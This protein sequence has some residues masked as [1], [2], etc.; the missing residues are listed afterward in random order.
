MYKINLTL[1]RT[2]TTKLSE[3]ETDIEQLTV[4][5]TILRLLDKRIVLFLLHS[6]IKH[7]KMSLV[8]DQVNSFQQAGIL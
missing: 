6:K 8:Q 3:E 5:W 2:E 4:K 1:Q 7:T